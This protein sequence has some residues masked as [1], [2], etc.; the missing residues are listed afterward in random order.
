L[1][2]L[3]Q[4]TSF[5]IEKDGGGSFARYKGKKYYLGRVPDDEEVDLEDDHMQSCAKCQKDARG[6]CEYCGCK[7]VI[8]VW[9]FSMKCQKCR[10]KRHPELLLLCEGYDTATGTAC[11]HQM[12]AF[13]VNPVVADID[14]EEDWLCDTCLV[15]SEKAHSSVQIGAP[16]RD[17]KKASKTAAKSNR[18]WGGWARSTNGQLSAGSSTSAVNYLA[19]V[20]ETVRGKVPGIL[21][22]QRFDSRNAVS[23]RAALI[24]MHAGGGVERAPPADVR[25]RVV[26]Q[27]RQRDGDRR[28][29][30]VRQ[31]RRRRRH[32]HVHWRGR[33]GPVGQQEADEGT[34]GRPVDERRSIITLIYCDGR[35]IAR[36]P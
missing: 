7:V 27:I 13:C 20:D 23:S 28:V 4:N 36:S 17:A 14:A 21:A 22:G 2:I 29:G 18:A 8:I 34:A 33:Q 16:E 6:E 35:R 25:H 24:V 30:R 5:Q 19:H 10:S 1:S 31:R 9:L 12:H 32:A 3:N 26:D 15:E 11:P